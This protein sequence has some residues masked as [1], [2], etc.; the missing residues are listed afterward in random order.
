MRRSAV[1]PEGINTCVYCG[2][3]SPD[4]EETCPKSGGRHT[5][6][7]ASD[8][9]VQGQGK[10]P[11]PGAKRPGGHAWERGEKA[12]PAPG[13]NKTAD[14][15]ILDGP[16]PSA[17]HT[18]RMVTPHTRALLR[19]HLHNHHGIDHADLDEYSGDWEGDHQAD[20]DD[21]NFNHFRGPR[22]RPHTHDLKEGVVHIAHGFSPTDEVTARHCP[23]CGSGNIWGKSDGT[24]KCE[25]CG[26]SFTIQVQPEYPQMAQNLDGTPLDMETGAPMPDMEGTEEGG[27][28]EGGGGPMENGPEEGGSEDEA[29]EG[30]PEDEENQGKN[31]GSGM[32]FGAARKPT[33]LLTREGN[34]LSTDDLINY[35]A[36]RHAP[37][38]KIMAQAVKAFNEGR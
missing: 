24:I 37:D 21:P 5:L 3:E 2:A 12:T 23:F 22:L 32:P 10:G 30:S 17:P 35:L 28:A 14:L 26:K 16:E 31:S 20:H 18:V 4:S 6:V 13:N 8:K 11:G 25:F 34:V 27:D 1:T 29:D 15:G 33:F 9:E 7:S 36:I 38:P 19:M